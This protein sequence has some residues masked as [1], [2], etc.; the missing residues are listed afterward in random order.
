V[1]SRR[2]L[3]ARHA[4]R[5]AAG[6]VAVAGLLRLVAV[7]P[8]AMLVLA[9][10][11]ALLT[12]L[13]VVA[14]D[15]AREPWTATA[16]TFAWGA[17]VAASTATALNATLG[18]WLAGAIG[19]EGGRALAP[20]VVGPVVEEVA[21]A[22]AL[23]LLLA[24]WRERLDGVRDGIVYGALVGVGFAMAENVDYF[25]L[26]AV[27][28]GPEGLRRSV[29]TRAF[30]GALNH[31]VFA[32]TTGAA[33]GWAW[34]SPA[35]S[36]RLAAPLVGLAA[37]IT[38]HVLWNTTAA[39]LIEHRLCGAPAPGAACLPSPALAD[40]VVTTPLIVVVFL[41]PIAAGL[42]ALLAMTSRDAATERS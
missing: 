31:A 18:A 2:T 35:G 6:V 13:V 11:P 33:V 27:Q 19:A 10:G 25:T 1:T 14:A 7:A 41:A 39:P 22:A 26:A 38:E 15:G 30:V 34:R 32:A 28:A 37:A 20:V 40:L 17:V 21:K 24:A 12:A 23:V 5:V 36:A 8:P 42:G 16:A 3:V 4:I 9:V 29:Y